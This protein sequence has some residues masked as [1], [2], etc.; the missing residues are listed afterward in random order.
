[1]DWRRNK[2]VEFSSGK[3]QLVSFNQSK[4]TG[5][6][7]VKMDGSVLEKKSFFKMF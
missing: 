2:P 3:I 1:M 7:D 6:S 4:I 5:A